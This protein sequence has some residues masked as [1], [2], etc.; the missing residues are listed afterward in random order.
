M[1]CRECF[2][3]VDKSLSSPILLNRSSLVLIN[4]SVHSDSREE[5]YW[6][7]LI[8]KRFITITMVT[9]IIFLVYFIS[10]TSTYSLIH[11]LSQVQGVLLKTKLREIS[12]NFEIMA[13]NVFGYFNHT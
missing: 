4:Y 3:T 10:I 9:L 13:L 11:I 1:G 2:G 8:R 12:V 5:K 7:T 6:I